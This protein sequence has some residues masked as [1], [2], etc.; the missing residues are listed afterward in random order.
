[1]TEE[2]KSLGFTWD[3]F[4]FGA[5]LIVVILILWIGFAELANDKIWEALP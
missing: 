5:L 4:G 2:E 3:M 1:M